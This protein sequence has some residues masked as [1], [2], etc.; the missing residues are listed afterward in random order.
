MFKLWPVVYYKKSLFW[1]L[2]VDLE[3]WDWAGDQINKPFQQIKRYIEFWALDSASKMGPLLSG[4]LF[5]FE[6]SKLNVPLNL[7]KW[8]IALI[9]RPISNL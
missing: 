2:N 4:N 6:G 1:V 3:V 8:H 9:T 5:E 7:L